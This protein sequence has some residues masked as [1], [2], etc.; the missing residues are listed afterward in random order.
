MGDFT[1]FESNNDPLKQQNHLHTES[2]QRNITSLYPH[3]LGY[4]Q[5]G[6]TPQSAKD[7]SSS[8]EG[9]QSRPT[10]ASEPDTT[11][12]NDGNDD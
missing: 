10:T 3:K 12:N 2:P 11:E 1:S 9:T 4:E 8:S 5:T 6:R 7:D